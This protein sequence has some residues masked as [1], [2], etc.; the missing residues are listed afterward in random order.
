ML[1]SSL[2]L[3]VQS[4]GSEVGPLSFWGQKSCGQGSEGRCRVYKFIQMHVQSL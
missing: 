1:M 2:N 3:Q 4:R